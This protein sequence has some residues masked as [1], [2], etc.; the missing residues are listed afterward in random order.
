ML[1][2][3]KCIVRTAKNQQL[4]GFVLSSGSGFIILLLL[5]YIYFFNNSIQ[6]FFLVFV[7]VITKFEHIFIAKI[8]TFISKILITALLLRNCKLIFYVYLYIGN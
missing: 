4:I 2:N 1:L 7:F 5:F 3:N 6:H 8:F